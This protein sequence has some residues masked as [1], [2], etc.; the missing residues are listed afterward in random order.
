[1]TNNDE[2][3]Q[4][5]DISRRT[6]WITAG[7]LLGGL[8]VGW[9][10]RSSTQRI[11]IPHSHI[12]TVHL[13][14]FPTQAGDVR[15]LAN[16]AVYVRAEQGAD[17]AVQHVVRSLSCTH[18]RCPLHINGERIVCRCHG[19]VFDLSGKP[20]SGPPQRSLDVCDTE[21]DGDVCYIRLPS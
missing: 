13:S 20:V 21:T 6:W 19:G 17:G 3:S 15:T 1:M 2:N 10:F 12:L 8:T 9:L 18:A 11:E 7:T 14:E 16:G 4:L 5:P